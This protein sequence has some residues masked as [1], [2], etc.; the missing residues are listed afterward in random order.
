MSGWPTILPRCGENEGNLY[1]DPRC[2]RTVKGRPQDSH[3]NDAHLV[4]RQFLQSS[5]LLPGCYSIPVAGHYHLR[6]MR[7]RAGKRALLA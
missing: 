5:A 7:Y 1:K 2:T 4:V 6:E 3:L